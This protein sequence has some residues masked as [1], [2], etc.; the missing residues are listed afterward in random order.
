MVV[1][2]QRAPVFSFVK[3]ADDVIA[4][5]GGAEF[6]WDKAAQRVRESLHDALNA[7]HLS[8][9]FG[10]GCSSLV[11]DA[12]QRGIDTMVPLAREFLKAA[13]GADDENFPSQAE[14]DALRTYLGFD[15]D[16][17]EFAGNLERL[18]EVLYSVQFVLQ[19]STNA[20]MLQAKEA[21]ASLIRKVTAF[22]TRKCSDT[23]FA[24]GDPTVVDLYQT[25]YRRLAFRDRTLPRPWI[26]TTNYDLISET[27]LD[28][29]GM[30]YCNGFSGTVE[31]RF[32]PT[33]Y[34]YALAEQLDLSSRKWAAVDNFIYLC[35]LHGSINWVEQGGSLFPIRE[36]HAP[37]AA[38]KDGRVMI[39]PT[40]MKQNASFGSPYSDLFREFQG[41]IV[42][43]QSVLF[44]L[45]Y[46][47]GDEH[48]NNL[49]F[50][51]LTVP[52]FRLVAFLAPDAGGVVQ[53]LRDL[54]DPRI[55][56][57]GGDGPAA[58]SRAH[59]FNTFV[60]KFMPESPGDKVDN[61]VKKVLQELIANGVAP[62][63]QEE[64]GHEH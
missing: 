58:G 35:K 24:N 6:D 18:M 11:V 1:G 33:T 40:P 34:R 53:K 27:A 2:N 26:F 63:A 19:R 51:A 46:S 52:T 60:D 64:G 14:R 3:G 44:V 4:P 49:I 15:L 61:A 21:V 17:G 48:V 12:I 57:I 30:P 38:G 29:L 5:K 7:R 25:F 55:W 36:V 32:N 39:Y 41:R 13:P 28:R 8:F 9:L 37:Q 20:E 50:Q 54:K 10:S 47:F 59:Y 56:L 42:R 62:E 22:V 23:P 43:E 16:A 31:R 45:G